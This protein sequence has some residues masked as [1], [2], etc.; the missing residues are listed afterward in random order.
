MS[1]EDLRPPVWIGHVLLPTDRVEES[2]AF[3][4]KLGLRPL[5][6]GEG[7]A[8]LEL[9]A[10]THLVLTA[11][12]DLVPGDAPFD[13][14]VEDIDATRERLSG[15]GLDPSEMAEGTIHRSF[16]VRDPSGQ[17]ITFN[18]SHNSDQPV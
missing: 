11:T 17:Q 8:V 16:T 1:A 10:G 12:E 15:L 4:V 6:K 7:F 14:M 18:S 9:R 13:L 2:N 3:M 5:A